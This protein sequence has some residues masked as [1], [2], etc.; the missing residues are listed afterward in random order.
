[1]VAHCPGS[2]CIITWLYPLR[3]NSDGLE[4][5]LLAPGSLTFLMTLLL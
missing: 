4:S 3:L 5:V 1:M 2:E